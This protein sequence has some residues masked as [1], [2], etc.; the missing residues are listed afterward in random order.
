MSLPVAKACAEAVQA[1]NGAK[2]NYT[3]F[4]S[5]IAAK[6]LVVAL[7]KA[8]P[9]PPTREALLQA[10]AAVGR[11]DL[12]GYSLNY[13]AGHRHGSSLVEL[14]ILARGSRFVQ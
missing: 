2:L 9:K 4:E 5:C 11:I 10:M 12:G 1:L 7:K 13:A 8:G 3:S 6:A 14:T